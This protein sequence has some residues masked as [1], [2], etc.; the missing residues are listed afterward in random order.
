MKENV[1]R[2]GIFIMATIQKSDKRMLRL[3]VEGNTVKKA[4][5]YEY[6]E[7]R[8]E[9]I[10]IRENEKNQKLFFVKEFSQLNKWYV[11]FL[12]LACCLTVAICVKYIRLKVTYITTQKQIVRLSDELNNIRRDNDAKY[13][14]IKGSVDMQEVKRIATEEYGMVYPMEH[15]I[16]YYE[17]DTPDYVKQFKEIP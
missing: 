3:Y 4:E 12:I 13:D 15:Q 7:L 17:C 9:Q 1:L 11:A 10:R 6:K 14:A 8:E 16:R 2:K 5:P